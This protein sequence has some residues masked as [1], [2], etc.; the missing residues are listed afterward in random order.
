MAKKT[1]VSITDDIDGTENA[2]TVTFSYDGKT[3]EIDLA[4]KNKA[5][6]EKALESFI[7]AARVTSS[8]RSSTSGTKSNKEELAAIRS[9]AKSN[10]IAV[11]ERGRI[12]NDVQE[13]YRSVH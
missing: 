7:K 3:Y 1:V 12:S 6:L 10:G 9:W 11:S 2:E 5:A 4:E 8:R 13:A